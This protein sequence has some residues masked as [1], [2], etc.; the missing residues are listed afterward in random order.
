MTKQMLVITAF[1]VSIL[2][3]G[4]Y[5]MWIGATQN[6][7]TMLLFGAFYVFVLIIPILWTRSAI[8]KRHLMRRS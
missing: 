2:T 7:S 6:N 5:S 1:L 4:I 3:Y 8:K